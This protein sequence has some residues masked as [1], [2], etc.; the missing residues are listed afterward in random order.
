PIGV[1]RS[2]M[3]AEYREAGNTT[4][5]GITYI[6]QVFGH[7]TTSI[8][9]AKEIMQQHTI[10]IL[11]IIDRDTKILI[12]ILTNDTLVRKDIQYYSTKSLTELS[13]DCLKSSTV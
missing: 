12:G 9:D 8:K 7:Y 2:D 13:L 4:L 6:P 3:L 11:P 10:N 5:A 1:V